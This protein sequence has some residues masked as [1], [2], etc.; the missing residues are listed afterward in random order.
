MA[1]I[2]IE[3]LKNRMARLQKA[4]DTV[5]DEWVEVWT[6][7]GTAEGDEAHEADKKEDELQQ[8]FR[9]LEAQMKRV[10]IDIVQNVIASLDTVIM[11]D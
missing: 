4:H 8:K 5:D 2:P 9:R 11:D 6:S 7:L 1:N 10:K 3:R